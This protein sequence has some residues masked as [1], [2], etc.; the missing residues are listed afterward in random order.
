M[1]ARCSRRQLNAMTAAGTGVPAFLARYR[2]LRD[3]LPGD[4]AARDAAADSFRRLGF[5][6][7]G[8]RRRGNTPICAP[9]RSRLPRTTQRCRR[10]LLPA[11]CAAHRRHPSGVSRRPVPFGPVR[12]RTRH[13]HRFRRSTDCSAPVRP[14][15]DPMAALNTMLAEDGAA[16]PFH[17]KPM[18]GPSTSQSSP[19]A[20]LRCP[21]PPIRATSSILAAAPA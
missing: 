5:P 15:R 18:P 21:A 4:R 9:C 3:R 7:R 19:P 14:D 8:V 1:P 2:G 17:P 20:A 10:R 13:L 16:S 12:R 11:R 6:W